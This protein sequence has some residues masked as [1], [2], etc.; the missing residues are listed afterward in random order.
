MNVLLHKNL[1]PQSLKE[2]ERALSVITCFKSSFI[3]P[4]ASAAGSFFTSTSLD[5]GAFAARG[6][7]SSLRFPD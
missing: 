4:N 7:F 1:F 5:Y 6:S 2:Q 3:L